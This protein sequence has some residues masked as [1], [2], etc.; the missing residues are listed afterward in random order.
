MRIKICYTTLIYGRIA[1]IP[2]KFL[3]IYICH[4]T[5]VNSSIVC[6]KYANSNCDSVGHN[7]LSY[8]GSADHISSYLFIYLLV[9]IK[10][11]NQNYST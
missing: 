4:F 7:G 9:R 1:K 10:I 8:R 11:S 3:A 2:A 6:C 5:S